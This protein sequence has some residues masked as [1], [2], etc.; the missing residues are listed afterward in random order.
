MR[1]IE[2]ELSGFTSFREQ[3]LIDFRD[4]DYFVLVGQTG[5][6]KS[7]VIDAIC[8]ALYGSVPRYENRNL[9]APVI[10][11]G[12]L[13]AKVRLDFEIDS[14]IYTAVRVVR[15]ASGK[16]ATTK[17][18]RLECDGEV[19][20]G[21]ADDLTAAVADLIGLSF[22]HFTKCVVLPQGEFSRFLH[23]KPA[24][25]QDM[26]VKLLG[27]N[28]YERM[29]QQASTSAGDLKTRAAMLAE[30]LETDFDDATPE[31]LKEAKSNLKGLEKLSKQVETAMPKLESSARE[32]ASAE[33][34]IDGLRTWI[35][36]LS[37]LRIPSSMTEFGDQ[38]E[39]ANKE[40]NE[41]Q[42][43]VTTA[44]VAT[45]AALAVLETLPDKGP[46]LVAVKAHQRREEM[47]AQLESDRAVLAKTE[48]AVTRAT[49]TMQKAEEA[50]AAAD[51]AVQ[52]ARDDHAA[53]HL[54]ASL[55]AGEPCPVCLQVVDKLPKH[56]K[57]TAIAAADRSADQA[58]K[59]LRDASIALEKLAADR[60]ALS[61]AVETL[62]RQI[63][64]LLA[65][66]EAHPDPQKLQALV[67]EATAAENTLSSART[68]ESATRADL[69][70]A[71]Q[72]VLALRENEES[73]RRR[74]EDLRDSLNPLQP[75]AVK[76]KDLVADW[77]SLLEWASDKTQE[78]KKQAG[79]AEAE[80]LK[81]R[82]AR[83]ATLQ[84]LASACVDCELDI[85]GAAD[86]REVVLRA[87]LES[88]AEVETLAKDIESSKRLRRDL[89]TA[90]A[91]HALH[92][93][94][95]RHLSA[96]G[97]ERWLVEEAVRRLVEGATEIL[98]ELSNGQYSLQADKNGNFL[99]T[100]H[101]NA[102]ETR[103]A[104]T[105]SGGET[106]L[107][108]LSLALSLSDQLM[109][110]AA[111]GSAR[112]DAIFLDEGFG[113]LDPETLDTV[114]AT[115]ENL[116]AGGRMVGIITHVRDLADRVPLQFQVTKDARTST[117]TKVVV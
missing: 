37:V 103:S 83:D 117:V 93:S 47:A 91:E 14:K 90:E 94:L 11:Q 21:N 26:L 54:A 75:P 45:T 68:K 19:I 23:D 76:R 15:R 99:V 9:V 78:I 6:G 58:R 65:D 70:K 25:R 104:K 113:T 33:T 17:E 3:T 96:T 36:K 38:L 50:V 31:A 12:Q 71:Q 16:G 44:E 116:A 29:R 73:E 7:T 40:M 49:A 81:T 30:R 64:S 10:T 8:F 28:V 74:F 2:L 53:L 69:N 87:H 101:H 66:V 51:Q 5:S 95:A 61:A 100:D 105:L 22:E 89:K 39:R 46:L 111:Q 63:T 92:S 20:A 115:V 67:E 59:V 24:D 77:D 4:A 41:A 57:A 86:L 114:A 98:K 52:Q 85:E 84:E 88:S 35:E 109:E 34:E 48:A 110:L 97:F 27:M 72:K 13:E 107:A 102:N 82:K 55:D 42:A 112:L 106:F 62:D 1:P 60:T 18:A 108:S 80:V 43:S 56:P 79:A 32:I